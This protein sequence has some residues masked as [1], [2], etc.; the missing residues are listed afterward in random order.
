[1]YPRNNKVAPD[2]EQERDDEYRAQT[3][4]SVAGGVGAAAGASGSN[5]GAMAPIEEPKDLGDMNTPRDGDYL[6]TSPT[7]VR[8]GTD[9]L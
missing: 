2:E 7:L 3:S 6:R 8:P 5:K 9:P 1:M 4:A